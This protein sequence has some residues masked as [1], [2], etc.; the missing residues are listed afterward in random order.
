MRHLL[1]WK[2]WRNIP[3][4]ASVSLRA[5]MGL[6]LGVPLVQDGMRPQ[7]A[8]PM[9]LSF[10][11]FKRIMAMDWEGAML[12]RGTSLSSENSSKVDWCIARK[13]AGMRSARRKVYRP[14]MGGIL[15][16]DGAPMNTDEEFFCHRWG[17]DGHR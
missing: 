10:F 14:H 16:T 12:N 7:L 1:R 17:T 5:L 9:V 4:V 2:A 6:D 13:I 11:E 8:R 3:L 15:A